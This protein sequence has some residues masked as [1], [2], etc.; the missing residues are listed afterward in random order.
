MATLAELFSLAK[1]PELNCSDMSRRRCLVAVQVYHSAHCGFSVYPISFTSFGARQN[2]WSTAGFLRCSAC[3]VSSRRTRPSK[4]GKRALKVGPCTS[5]SGCGC[6]GLGRCRPWRPS[7]LPDKQTWL[8][9][10]VDSLGN[11]CRH[12]QLNTES[13]PPRRPLCVLCH[14]GP[15]RP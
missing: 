11:L 14:S 10:T 13:A 4:S 8:L 5:K 9:C 7:S 2:T 3:K 6:S 1:E 12:E 15:A